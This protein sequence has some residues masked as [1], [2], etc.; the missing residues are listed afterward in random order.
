MG[1]M[2]ILIRNHPTSS[3]MFFSE[4]HHGGSLLT[5]SIDAPECGC[6]ATGPSLGVWL[7]MSSN[8]AGKSPI[9]EGFAMFEWENHL[10]IL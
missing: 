10:Q 6:V 8:M 1:W 9:N 5:L 4:P 7:G 3:D 2:Y